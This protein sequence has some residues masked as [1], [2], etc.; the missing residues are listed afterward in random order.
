[1]LLVD[2]V[3]ST[4]W[5]CVNSGRASTK[6]R[7]IKASVA[8]RQGR[9]GPE[10]GGRNLLYLG[11]TSPNVCTVLSEYSVAFGRLLY[12]A[13][14]WPLFG[15]SLVDKVVLSLMCIVVFEYPAKFPWKPDPHRKGVWRGRSLGGD[16]ERQNPPEA[17]VR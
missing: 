12:H 9:A 1:M 3:T 4:S 10:G 14:S 7:R 15:E 5:L 17:A 8:E 16:L 2:S 13:T 11:A 6:D